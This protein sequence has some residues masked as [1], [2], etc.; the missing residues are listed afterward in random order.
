MPMATTQRNGKTVTENRSDPRADYI[1]L[2][3]DGQGAYHVFR[4][5][6]ETVHVVNDVEREHVEQLARGSK[7]DV[8]MEFVATRRGWDDRRYW[9]TLGEAFDAAIG[10]GD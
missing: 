9:P 4:T 8:W 3:R 5:I 1:P 10:G 7:I 6:D 2:G